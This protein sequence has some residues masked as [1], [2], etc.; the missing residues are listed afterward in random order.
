[1]SKVTGMT[2]VHLVKT[3]MRTSLG[4]KTQMMNGASLNTSGATFRLSVRDPY[5]QFTLR[6]QNMRISST[7][8]NAKR[9]EL[10]NLA[11]PLNRTKMTL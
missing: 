7:G 11:A 2:M 9:M 4:V 6:V 5:Q 10:N 1:M 3:G 8:R